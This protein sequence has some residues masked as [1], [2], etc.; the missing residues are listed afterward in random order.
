MVVPVL[1]ISMVAKLNSLTL[2]YTFWLAF[3]EIH[4]I[5]RITPFFQQRLPLTKNVDSPP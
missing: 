5:E 3:N 2:G 1:Y 4:T